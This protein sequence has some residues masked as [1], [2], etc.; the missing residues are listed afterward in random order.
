MKP[1][2]LLQELGRLQD[3]FAWRTVIA[4]LIDARRQSSAAKNYSLENAWRAK[5]AADLHG[6]LLSDYRLRGDRAR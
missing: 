1:V 2:E 3:A 4:T 5:L 6:L